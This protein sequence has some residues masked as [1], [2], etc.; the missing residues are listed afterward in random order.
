MKIL[1]CCQVLDKNH[2]ILGFFHRWVLEFSKHFERVDVICLQ[3]GECELPAHVYVHTLGKEDGES[4]LKYIYRFYANFSKIFFTVRVDFVF[5]HMGAIFNVLAAPF[6]FMRKIFGTK[7]YW[8]KAHGHINHFGRFA[9]T[10]VDRV[11]TSTESGFPILSPKRHIVG[12]AIDVTQFVLPDKTVER[13]EKVLYVGRVVPIKRIEDFQDTAFTLHGVFPK[14]S[15]HVI[16]PVGD[17]AYFKTQE[18]KRDALDAVSYIHFEGP[19]IQSE[20]VPLYQKARVFLNTSLTHS[21]DKTVLEAILCGC[22]P[23]TSNK[24]FASLLTPYGL[25]ASEPTPSEYAKILTHVLKSDTEVLSENLRN[26]VVGA[27]SLETFPRR[28]FNV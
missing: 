9:L 14:L 15:W 21:M 8:W 1:I 11:Y 3:K 24:A 28:I 18:H 27:H 12:Q 19:K 20:L 25:Y 26:T 22:I 13:Q 4:N 5:F 10:F 16:G 2:A 23:V 7:F 6:F 17:E